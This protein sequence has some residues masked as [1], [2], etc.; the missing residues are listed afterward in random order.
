MAFKYVRNLLL[1][2][3]DD[4]L[5]DNEQFLLLFDLYSLRQHDFPYDNYEP[6]DLNK[7]DES[8]C[9]AEFCCRKRDIPKLFEVL[10]IPDPI[11][12]DQRS[13]CSG[14]EG[15]CM[16]LKRMSYPCRYGDMVH[17]FAK[18]VPVLSII[19]NQVHDFIYDTHKDRVIAWNHDIL[20][21]VKLQTYADAIADKGAPFGNC[22]G[23]I[24]GIVRAISR[25]GENQRIEYSSVTSRC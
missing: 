22:F 23:F 25:S 5:I 11:I 12:C 7:F 15:L 8:E 17:T 14:I 16:L 24:D 3:H 1:L 9:V 10:Q 21:P 4:G 13:I 20:N 19:T 6:F 18:P 2:S